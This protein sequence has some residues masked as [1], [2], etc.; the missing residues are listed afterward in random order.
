MMAEDEIAD[1]FR[2]SA[3]DLIRIADEMP[4]TRDSLDAVR[5]AGLRMRAHLLQAIADKGELKFHAGEALNLL[6]V[7]AL[8]GHRCRGH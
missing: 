8:I 1:V 5:R 3:E 2:K 4:P 6:D 7:S